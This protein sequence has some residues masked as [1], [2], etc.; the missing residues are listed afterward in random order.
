MYALVF[1]TLGVA[2]Q[3]AGLLL[4]FLHWRARRGLGGAALA[5]GWALVFAGAAPWFANAAPERALALAALAPMALGLVL[6]A[7]DAW[8]RIAAGPWR[9]VRTEPAADP[10]AETPAPG[11]LSRSSARWIASI[12]AAPALAFAAAAAWQAFAPGPPVDQIVFSTLVTIAVWTAAALWLLST[13]KP[14]RAT[15]IALVLAAA[16]GAATSFKAI[17]GLV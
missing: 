13:E 12:V 3:A 14:W 5:V 17:G 8:P 2:A 4:L 9:R 11:R 10:D 16:I 15:M 7:P 1:Q 6:L